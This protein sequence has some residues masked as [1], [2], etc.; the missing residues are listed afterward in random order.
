M[1]TFGID[2][3]EY[4]KHRKE[5]FTV[6]VELEEDYLTKQLIISLLVSTNG[7]HFTGLR[8]T[9]DE[10]KEIKRKVNETLKSGGA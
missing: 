3:K 9:K 2:P 8:F 6:K 10:W 7:N 1:N 5:N 4:I